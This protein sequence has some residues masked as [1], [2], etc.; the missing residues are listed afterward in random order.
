MT[1]IEAAEQIASFLETH[2][3]AY[4]LIGGIAVQQWGEP[5]ATRDVDVVVMVPQ[6]RFEAFVADAVERFRAR[7]PDPLDFA[8]RTRVLLL[9][10]EDGI[11]LDVSFGIPGYEDEVMRRKVAVSFGADTSMDVISA[12]DLIVH[13]CLAGRARDREDVAHILIRQ[14]DALDLGYVR[15]WLRQFASF[16]EEH[17]VEGSFEE[18]VRRARRNG[19]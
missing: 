17:D 7:I 3:I 6:E 10:T 14:G 16:V 15:K 13:K 5:R 19:P 12:E 11:P 9:E 4:A 1:I 2:H 8:R 18:A